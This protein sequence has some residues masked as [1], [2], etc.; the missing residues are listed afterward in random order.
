[1]QFSLTLVLYGYLDL[2]VATL[3]D[4]EVGPTLNTKKRVM[5]ESF[6]KKMG[7]KRTLQRVLIANNG[8]RRSS[9]ILYFIIHI[10]S[11]YNT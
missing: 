1:M 6:V 10:L 8:T 5:V 4:I 3:D 2:P 9:P 11:L 7:G